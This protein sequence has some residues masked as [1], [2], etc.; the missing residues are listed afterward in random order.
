MRQFGLRGFQSSGA[1]QGYARLTLGIIAS[2]R[3]P[4][5]KLAAAVRL[6]PH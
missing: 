4:V 5:E 1:A 3:L 6:C 2:R